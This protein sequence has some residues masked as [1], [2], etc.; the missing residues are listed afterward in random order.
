M[1][2]GDLT[3]NTLRFQLQPLTNKRD[4][5]EALAVNILG[6]RFVLLLDAQELNKYPGLRDA[7]YRPGRILISYPV[8]TNWVTLSW[9]D[10][11]AHD[12]LT[13][14]WVQPR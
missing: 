13:V 12:A 8:S 3:E 9:D 10:G 11:K 14:Q 2:P 6:F 7:Q 4:D 5:I 1:N